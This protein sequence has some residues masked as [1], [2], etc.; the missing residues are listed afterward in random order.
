MK[1]CNF[2]FGHHKKIPLQKDVRN[3]VE[4]AVK[5]QPGWEKKSAFNRAQILFYIGKIY[6]F[7]LHNMYNNCNFGNIKK[8]LPAWILKILLEQYETHEYDFQQLF[9]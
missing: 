2:I 6:F 5:A 8:R 3:A 1:N 4:V 7:V 9:L